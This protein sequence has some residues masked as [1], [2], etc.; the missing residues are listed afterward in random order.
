MSEE[1]TILCHS[2]TINWILFNSHSHRLRSNVLEER[3]GHNNQHKPRKLRLASIAHASSG[4]TILISEFAAHV[5][6]LNHLS[7][8]RP[9]QFSKKAGLVDSDHDPAVFD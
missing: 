7:L 4:Y 8:P 6:S 1:D 2:K 5:P 9:L 3:N